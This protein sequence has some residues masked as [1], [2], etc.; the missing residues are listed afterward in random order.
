MSIYMYDEAIVKSFRNLVND[1]R[2]TITPP[3]NV[4]RTIGR[5]AE[6]RIEFPLISLTRTGMSINM[7]SVQHFTKFEGATVEYDEDEN[8]FKKIQAIPIRINYLVDVWTK[9]RKENDS[10]IRELIFYYMTHPTLE[11]DIPYG[12]DISHNFN[13]FLDEDIDDN[14]DIV[15]HKNRGEYFRQTLSMYTDD[16]YIW[17][18][19]SRAP[20]YIEIDKVS[21]IEDDDIIY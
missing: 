17:K 20:T 11:V 16:A 6:D 21:D 5:I 13:L 2:I 18:S 8:K 1:N 14:S 4:F 7:S 15:E 3:D 19:S 10:I 12:L 9:S